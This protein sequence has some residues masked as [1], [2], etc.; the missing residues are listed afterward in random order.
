MELLKIFFYKINLRY[1]LRY[2]NEYDIIKKLTL[3][4]KVKE[5]IFL[6]K[7]YDPWSCP[8]NKLVKERWADVLND[9]M[10]SASIMSIKLD[11]IDRPLAILDVVLSTCAH[12]DVSLDR[13]VSKDSDERVRL[14]RKV[15]VYLVYFEGYMITKRQIAKLMNRKDGSFAL[16]CIDDVKS[17]FISDRT[18]DIRNDVATIKKSLVTYSLK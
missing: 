7:R 15:M 10:S 4:I 18:G 8:V 17:L 16:R 5:V 2:I 6:T 9:E 1:K 3:T 13:V 12:Y 14:A 11:M